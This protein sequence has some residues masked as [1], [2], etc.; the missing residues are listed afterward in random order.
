VRVSYRGETRAV[1]A[2]LFGDD[3]GRQVA[4]RIDRRVDRLPGLGS[5]YL[6]EDAVEASLD[7]DRDASNPSLGWKRPLAKLRSLALQAA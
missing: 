7:S 4:R 1:T 5:L 2:H 6:I 3:Q